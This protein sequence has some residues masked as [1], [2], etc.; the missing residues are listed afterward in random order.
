MTTSYLIDSHIW[1]WMLSD[2]P[3]LRPRMRAIIA[4]TDNVLLLSMASI[5]ELAIKAALGR[6]RAPLSTEGELLSALAHSGVSVLPIE[7]NDALSVGALPL[8]HGDPFDRMIVAQAMERRIPVITSDPW[9]SKYG[10]DSIT[11]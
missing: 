3:R 10:V 7:L 6:L 2:S 5:W 1:L 4:D 11:G 8:H 9:I